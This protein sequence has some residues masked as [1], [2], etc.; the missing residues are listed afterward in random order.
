[1]L[2]TSDWEDAVLVARIK[3]LRAPVGYLKVEAYHV[4]PSEDTWR[5]V[6]HGV[7]TECTN[8]EKLRRTGALEFEVLDAR[9]QSPVITF[10]GK[11]VTYAHEYSGTPNEELDG[12]ITLRE[13]ECNLADMKKS[14]APGPDAIT[15][16]CLYN[17]DK[18]TLDELVR[19]FND[20][21][22]SNRITPDVWKSAEVGR[23][24]VATRVSL[25][26]RQRWQVP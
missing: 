8:E 1:M 10:A 11:K 21:H 14:T 4:A 15:T 22:W 26:H 23:A 6:L 25:I 19:N 2:C 3:G 18:G 17:I 20:N 13:L 5:R 24:D 16:K 7:R 12:P 9:R